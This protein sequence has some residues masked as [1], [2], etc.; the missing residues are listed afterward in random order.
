MDAIKHY[1]D[2]TFSQQLAEREVYS[3]SQLG[4]VINV[5]PENLSA[6]DI[7]FFNVEEDRGCAENEG[8]ANGG[9]EVRKY[10]FSLN[11]HFHKL[12]IA[13]AGTVKAGS[14]I[15]D[16][17]FAVKEI[18][19]V[20][21]KN[22]VI[23]LIIGGSQD[24]TYA[25]YLAYAEQE[26]LVNLVEVNSRFSLGSNDEVINSSNWLSKV[27]LHQP[28]ILFNYSNIGFQ[29]YFTNNQEF[30]LLDEMFYDNYRLGL[31]KADIKTAEPIIRNAD[32]VSFNL[33]SIAQT[34][35]P[36][37]KTTSPNGFNS[38]QACQLA[39]YIGMNDKLSS[40]GIYGFN[41][42]VD[43]NGQTAHLVAQMIWCFI[44]AVSNRKGDFPVGNKKECTKFHVTVESAQKELIFYKSQ[45][46]ERW[47]MEIPY[48]TSF[49]S[50][51]E[52]HLMLPCDYE[53]YIEATNNE[54]PERWFQTFRKL[55]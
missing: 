20:L 38:E 40:F 18:V 54:I 27:L 15:S 39:R 5:N 28:N 19:S 51:Y 29:T 22:G 1:F 6:F 25:N 30:D 37:N 31:V 14:S 52:R 32:F 34:D 10:L 49:K 7:V 4:S 55:K 13:D 21:L 3:A 53:E 36:A 16:T 48:Q 45:K 24:L 35:A 33:S 47:W 50:K 23:P 2:S 12:T 17:Y 46:S 42:T 43:D 44:E 11:S 26:Q 8:C 41:P 9:N